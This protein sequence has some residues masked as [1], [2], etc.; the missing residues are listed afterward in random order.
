MPTLES[1]VCD[2]IVPF[3]HPSR[4]KMIKDLSKQEMRDYDQIFNLAKST[5]LRERLKNLIDDDLKTEF[6][7]YID[8]WEKYGLSVSEND[9]DTN[10]KF[11]EF[12]DEI[13]EKHGVKKDAYTK[14]DFATQKITKKILDTRCLNEKLTTLKIFKAAYQLGDIPAVANFRFMHTPSGKEDGKYRE[15]LYH[16]DNSNYAAELKLITTR[17]ANTIFSNKEQCLAAFTFDTRKAI[18]YTECE[19]AT[20]FA[21]MEELEKEFCG[22]PDASYAVIQGNNTTTCFE[23][24]L[25]TE[26]ILH[27][28][29][30]LST[31]D[32]GDDRD[33]E[34]M[35]FH[36]IDRCKPF[37]TED[38][39]SKSNNLNSL[40]KYILGGFENDNK[41]SFFEYF[42]EQKKELNDQIRNLL[43][44]GKL[45]NINDYVIAEFNSDGVNILNKDLF[46]KQKDTY[47]EMIDIIDT[48][49]KLTLNT[50]NVN[51]LHKIVSGL[52]NYDQNLVFSAD[53]AENKILPARTQIRERTDLC[54]KKPIDKDIYN[55]HFSIDKDLL[56]SMD[57]LIDV[58]KQISNIYS[59]IIENEKTEE[60]LT[61]NLYQSRVALAQDYTTQ[62]L[63]RVYKE[64]AHQTII[65]F[66]YYMLDDLISL[67]VL[68]NNN[69]DYLPWLQT[70]KIAMLQHFITYRMLTDIQV[71]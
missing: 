30:S 50:V 43:H 25:R 4:F 64:E 47:N 34:L 71:K 15:W 14:V 40:Q 65:L 26:M 55:V 7:K 8:Q 53:C 45:K 21:T 52:I 12:Y 18:R 3:S 28:R 58:C 11:K 19:A 22:I 38:E 62:L 1:T 66:I 16:F 9:D 69:P 23:T 27:H 60:H 67:T 20:K 36:G 2:Y 49:P 33:A 29:S 39:R 44:T 5:T 6:F 46:K 63:H 56:L 51:S 70:S 24:G 10:S 54:F 57:Q 13:V 17:L 42:Y 35:T 61:L 37:L 59:L 32:F 68:T 41:N 31:E 48:L